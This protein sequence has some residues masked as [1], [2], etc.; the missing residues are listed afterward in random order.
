MPKESGGCEKVLV[1]GLLL[2]L[3]QLEHEGINCLLVDVATL[4]VVEYQSNGS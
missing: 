3:V 1:T 2:S 4:L